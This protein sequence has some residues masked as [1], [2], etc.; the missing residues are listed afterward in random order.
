MSKEDSGYIY[1]HLK[2]DLKKFEMDYRANAKG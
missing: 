1:E 2:E